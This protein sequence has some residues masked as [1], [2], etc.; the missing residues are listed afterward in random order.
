MERGREF[1]GGPQGV[2]PVYK[3]L[4]G[5]GEEVQLRGEPQ[6]APGGPQ[7][8]GVVRVQDALR[9]RSWTILV[10][11]VGLPKDCFGQAAQNVGARATTGG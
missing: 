2:F 3:L 11:V 9:G 10:A 6:E 5:S 7:I 1:P 4:G 8:P